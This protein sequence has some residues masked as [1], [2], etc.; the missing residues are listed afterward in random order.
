MVKIT[1]VL[2]LKYANHPVWDDFGDGNASA[3]S[4]I[5][6][7][8]CIDDENR[9]EISGEESSLREIFIRRDKINREESSLKEDFCPQG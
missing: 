5:S 2:H 7:K 6:S 1:A 3:L 9:F 4:E 8:G